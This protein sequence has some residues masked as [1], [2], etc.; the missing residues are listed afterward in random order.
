[1]SRAREYGDAGGLISFGPGFTALSRRTAY[2]VVRILK[3]TAPADLPVEP[4]TIFEF[5]VN[6]HAVKA[7]GLTLP[8]TLLIRADDVLE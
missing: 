1:V 6:Q 3:G 7:L 4:P 5:V 8:L 2:Y